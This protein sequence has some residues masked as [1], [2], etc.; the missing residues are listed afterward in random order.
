[1]ILLLATTWMANQ[2]KSYYW[3][4]WPALFLLLTS[5]AALIYSSVFQA[6]YQGILVAL[7]LDVI[8]LIGN[9][10]TVLLGIF[11]ILAGIYLSYKG[12][13]AFKAVRTQQIQSLE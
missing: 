2:G 4:L 12:W 8:G 5:L 9:M 7:E 13:Q 6:L 3:T 1:L 10:L 11:F